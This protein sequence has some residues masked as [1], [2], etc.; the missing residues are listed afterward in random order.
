MGL[1]YKSYAEAKSKFR[2]S[3][4]WSVFDG[5]KERLNIAHECVD[6]HPGDDDAI[7]IKYADG[8]SE[9]HSFG[10][11]GRLTSQFAHFLARRGIEAGDRVAVILNPSLEFYVTLFGT[12]KRGAVVVPCFPAFGPE[13][14]A[15][16]LA[17]SAA[18]MVVTND[19]KASV[20]DASLVADIVLGGELLAL[21][22]DE[23]DEYVPHTSA[24]SPAVVQFSSGTT[25][26]PKI[27]PYKHAAA[28]LAA[29]NIKLVSGLR[30]EDRFYCPSSPAWGHGIW[31]GSIA[32]LVFGK[33]IGTYSGKFH[34]E[35]FLEALEEFGITLVSATP[36]VY[37][38]V[39]ESGRLNHYRLR[40]R[41]LSF[42]GGPL[43]LET[44]LYFRDRTGITPRSAYGTTEVGSLLLQHPYEDWE[45]RPGSMGGPMLGL[46]VAVLDE[47]GKVL[48]PGQIGQIAARRNDAWVRTGDAAY[49]DEDGHFWHK[50][51][52]D[53]II[54]SAGYTIGPQEIEEVLIKHPAVQRAA[55]VGSP[56][57]E[58]GE[59]VKAFIVSD[60]SA[61]E[62]LKRDIQEFIR[63]RLSKHEYPR[64][65]EFVDQ[66]PE[67]PDGKIKRK[68]LRGRE[69]DRKQ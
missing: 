51:R 31:F 45:V 32:P 63:T 22:R 58:R 13:A 57:L 43:D 52:V 3:E 50:G 59:I 28:T 29:V 2:Y 55:V 68:E 6:R 66:L 47:E 67:T 5:N 16:R 26:V 39:M 46:E 10:E 36:L 49:V 53:D 42:T 44:I 64:E 4:R 17:N 19:E 20:I 9:T 35:T 34:A 25:G 24:D 41:D 11:L 61:S 15:Y 48:P 8:R 7:R 40:L 12:L 1:D 62:E 38:M 54:I 69:R 56:D 33:A 23:D 65:I 21:L 30:P 37:R 27:V 14:I 18:R 60:R